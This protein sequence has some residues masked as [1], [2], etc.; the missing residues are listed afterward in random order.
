[1]N[2]EPFPDFTIRRVTG[3]IVRLRE[4]L[5]AHDDIKTNPAAMAAIINVCD[6]AKDNVNRPWADRQ[7]KGSGRQI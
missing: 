5:C 7:V 1:M 2:S 4:S 6:H 3:E